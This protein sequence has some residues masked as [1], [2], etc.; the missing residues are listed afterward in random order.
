MNWINLLL[1]ILFF[2]LMLFLHEFGHYLFAKLFKIKVEEFGFGFPP[3]IVKLF[4]FRET[5]VTLNWIP[6]GGFV[7]LAGDSDPSVEGGFAAAKPLARI[8][9]LLGGPLMN[10]VLGV[11]IFTL[12]FS[13]VGVPDYSKVVVSA[14]SPDSPAEAAGIQ[15]GDLI[16]EVNQTKIDSTNTLI[17]VIQ[18]N[19]GKEIELILDR[20]GQ[21]IVTQAVP[22]MDPPPNEGSLGI[23][24]TNPLVETSWINTV[25][26]AA[27]ATYQ[28]ASEIFSMPG[29][30]IRNEIPKDQA[31]I[32]GPVGIY[33]MFDKAR[34]QDQ[35][36]SGATNPYSTTFTMQLMAVITIAIGLTNLFPIPAVDGGRIVFIL[37][38]LLFRKRI[39]PKYENLVH[40][41]GFALLLALMF[42]VTAQDII[43]PI[44][45]P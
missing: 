20:S 1:F 33:S 7:R 32:V 22:R 34:Q 31:R 15:T 14:V 18:A 30:L 4:K 35:E 43:N 45:I 9:V 3:R 27:K 25:P 17:S 2:G 5:D 19:K 26:L 21:T 23:A 37:P 38:E 16:T 39:P 11:F 36:N 40:T 10:L 12:I 13:R 42:Y 44:Q 28:Q 8:G 29:R 24:M 41:L 6:F